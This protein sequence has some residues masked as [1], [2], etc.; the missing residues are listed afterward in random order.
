MGYYRNMYPNHSYKN[1]KFLAIVAALIIV[2]SVSGTYCVY[3]LPDVLSSMQGAKTPSHPGYAAALIS[4]VEDWFAG[5]PGW[6]GVYKTNPPST[7]GGSGSGGNGGVGVGGT[8]GNQ[9]ILPGIPATGLLLGVHVSPKDP[10]TEITALQNQI[11]RKFAIDSEYYNWGDL[12][13]STN[14]EQVRWDI[15]NGQLPMFS[16]RPLLVKNGNDNT[17]DTCGSAKDILAG[18]YDNQIRQQANSL[19]QYKVPVL[20]RWN[21]EMTDN[22]YNYCFNNGQQVKTNSPQAG[23]TYVSVWKYI[24]AIFVAQGA[25]NVQWVWAPSAN[26]YSN[27]DGSIDTSTWKLFYPG[28]DQVDWIADDQYNK[29]NTPESYATDVNVAHFYTQMT[30]LGK[31]LMQSETAANAIPTMVPPD[32]QT[33]WLTTITTAMTT[34]YPAFHALIYWNA[35]SS[36][37]QNN[38]KSGINYLLIGKG[39]ETFKQMATNPHFTAMAQL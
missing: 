8:G 2:I 5:I 39:L 19:K 29:T 10:E 23:A 24:H 3:T 31:P 15:Q 12:G 17:K 32:P 22:E 7:T 27:K 34:Q 37:Y 20:L 16:W 1:P 13:N 4:G 18:K 30:P 14:N 26:I 21:Y 36:M 25:T 33:E 38:P 9:T 6:G 35:D 28:S 11:G